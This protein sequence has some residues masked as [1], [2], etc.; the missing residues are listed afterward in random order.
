MDT[1]LKRSGLVVSAALLTAALLLGGCAATPDQAPAP[2]LEDRLD[3]LHAADRPA[4]RD[5]M[6]RLLRTEHR[7]IPA[8]HLAL[9]IET[10]NRGTDQALFL[11]SVWRYLDAR[12]GTGPRLETAADR[13]MLNL[14]AETA[15][16]SPGPEHRQRLESL[17]LTLEAEP[18]CAGE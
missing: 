9:A 15:L 10:F 2:T 8:K 16:R 5:E 3:A 17:C 6:R 13:R 4:W 14:Y 12:R 11:E 7:G 1:T 18:V